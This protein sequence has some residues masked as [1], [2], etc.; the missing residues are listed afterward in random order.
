MQ[1]SNR[2]LREERLSHFTRREFL[3]RAGQV[4]GAIAM[5]APGLGLFLRTTAAQ[6]A[7][8]PDPLEQASR[9]G[10]GAPDISAISS[11]LRWREL[12]PFRGGRVAA[13]TGVPGRPH[14][15]YFGAVN[16]GV[17]KSIDAGRIWKPVFDSQP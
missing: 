4:G 12:G 8:L 5:V 3:L 13:A 10:R 7:T 17:W 14:E 9:L 16:G 11:G 6:A 15:F 1:S 2:S